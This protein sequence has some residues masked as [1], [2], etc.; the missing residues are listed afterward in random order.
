MFD[1]DR[2]RRRHGR[3]GFGE[4]PP[5]MRPDWFEMWGKGERGPCVRRGD[6]RDAILAALAREPM[7]GYRIIQELAGQSGGRWRPSAGSIYP[8]LQQLEDEGLVTGEEHEGKRIFTLTEAGR[9]AAAK[10]ATGARPR[11]QAGVG[12]RSDAAAGGT[13]ATS[14][15]EF[16][17]ALYH[18]GA[19][20]MQAAQVGSPQTV[21]LVK[22]A[23]TEARKSIY[24]ALAEQTEPGEPDTK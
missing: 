14:P 18:L 23:L 1:R 9:E 6:V 5:D 2:G 22:A 3:A 15:A 8:T 12:P 17:E 16:R 20:V 7:H 11:W 24:R 10:A 19:A 4:M 13:A 21:A